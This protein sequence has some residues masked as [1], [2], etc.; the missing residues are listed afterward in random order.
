L[1]YF[2][3]QSRWNTEPVIA[4]HQ[5]K[6]YF[7]NAP[8]ETPLVEFVHISGTHW[9]IEIIFEESKGEI[10]FNHYEMRSWLGWHHHM[11]LVAF[12]HHFLVRLRVR[13]Y[14][15]SPALTIYQVRLL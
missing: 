4:I 9:H 7:S 6:Y 13:F 1:Q 12:A 15:K 11:L 2:E 5:L 3:G 10:G 8:A 14:E